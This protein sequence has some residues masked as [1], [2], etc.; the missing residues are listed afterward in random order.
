M[1]GFKIGISKKVLRKLQDSSDYIANC[2]SCRH[3]SNDNI[4]TNPNVTSFDIIKKEG[5]TYC[6][7]WEIERGGVNV[8]VCNSRYSK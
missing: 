8:K 7:F 2:Y 4:C 1:S 3:F 6:Y 5:R